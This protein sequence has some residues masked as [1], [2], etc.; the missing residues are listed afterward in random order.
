MTTHDSGDQYTA[1]RERIEA[2]KRRFA[3]EGFDFDRTKPLVI[4]RETFVS[5][6]QEWTCQDLQTVA[7]IFLHAAEKTGPKSRRGGEYID[8]AGEVQEA[9]DAQCP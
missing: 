1:T 5:A 9:H 8:L 6:N 7:D 4:D 2:L 3:D